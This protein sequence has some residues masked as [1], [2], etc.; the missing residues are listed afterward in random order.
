[1]EFGFVWF[2]L[3]HFLALFQIET[4]LVEGMMLAVFSLHWALLDFAIF[5][6]RLISGHD[7]WRNSNKALIND[8]IGFMLALG[9]FLLYY[10]S[11]CQILDKTWRKTLLNPDIKFNQKSRYKEQQVSEVAHHPTHKMPTTQIAKIIRNQHR[12]KRRKNIL[13]CSKS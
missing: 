8:N 5:N 11:M 3:V 1:M 6:F 9:I 12:T 13:V 4:R 7:T 2:W 10:R